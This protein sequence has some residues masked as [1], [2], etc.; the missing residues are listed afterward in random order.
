MIE[1]SAGCVSESSATGTVSTLVAYA[2]RLE[3]KMKMIEP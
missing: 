2:Q 1:L 3:Q